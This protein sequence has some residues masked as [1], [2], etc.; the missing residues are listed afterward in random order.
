M[1]KRDDDHLSRIEYIVR[2][3]LDELTGKRKSVEFSDVKPGEIDEVQALANSLA[4]AGDAPARPLTVTPT[5]R[6]AITETLADLNLKPTTRKE[7]GRHFEHMAQFFGEGLRLNQIDQA[8]FAA[9]ADFVNANSE[10]SDKSKNLKIVACAGLFNR[11]TGRNT[12]VP[13]II[14][15][16]LKT[17]RT[18]PA[19]HDR[20]AFTIDELKVI[21]ENAA[22]YRESEP[23]KWWI[24]VATAFLGCRVEELAQAHLSGDFNRDA[25]T[26]ALVLK[27]TEE[28][29]SGSGPTKSVKTLAGWRKVPVHPILEELGFVRFIDEERA[30]GSAT[31]FARQ[32]APWRDPG[33]GGVKH[34]HSA[35]K[36]GGREL[37]KLRAS[38]QIAT[39]KQTYFHSLRHTFTTLL[40]SAGIAEEWRAG[41]AGQAHGGVNSQIYNKA[42]EDV[43][44]TLPM[45]TAALKPLESII[46]ELA[47]D[48]LAR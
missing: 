37:E 45:V 8:R 42:R 7:Y 13:T 43:S 9:Y 28:I 3:D 26:G 23:C 29:D 34:S 41:L 14:T 47:K 25:S 6:E 21:L 16:G 1:P 44:Q 17:K 5:I 15:K 31:L 40:A 2:I 18:R 19:G 35:V 30:A 24:T 12:A 22:R 10:W 27:I 36:W 11:Y 32:W 38:G 4:P 46:R 39:G 20:D 33:T 48:S